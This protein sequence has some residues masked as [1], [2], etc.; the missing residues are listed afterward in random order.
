MWNPGT[1]CST[2]QVAAYSSDLATVCLQGVLPL[3][4]NH[5][6]SADRHA[7]DQ[8]ALRSQGFPGK[9]ADPS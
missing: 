4:H 9:M 3:T 2:A 1:P 5:S 8:E 7:M 6:P